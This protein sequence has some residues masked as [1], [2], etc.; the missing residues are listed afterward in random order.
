MESEILEK[1]NKQDARIDEM[2]ASMEKIRK[3]L[4]VMMW[5]GVGTVVVPI[6]GLLLVIPWFLNAYGQAF[7][8]LL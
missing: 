3:Y 1:L 2:L 8:G 6:L 4:L 7:D 5:I